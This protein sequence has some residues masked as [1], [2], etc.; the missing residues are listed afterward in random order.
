[1]L[2]HKAPSDYILATGYACTLK[3]FLVAAFGVVGLNWQDYVKVDPKFYRP[4]DSVNLVGN[5]DKAATHLSWRPKA[6]VT[7]LTKIM[8]NN[9]RTLLKHSQSKC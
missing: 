1:M 9:D 5:A 6:D 8:V 3:E 4:A 2:Q 7:E